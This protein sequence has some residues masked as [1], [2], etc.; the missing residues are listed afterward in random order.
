MCRR[1]RAASTRPVSEGWRG[2]VSSPEGRVDMPCVRMEKV[3]VKGATPARLACVQRVT[4]VRSS[5]APLTPR[6]KVRPTGK[7]FEPSGGG[8]S[9]S[10]SM[11]SWS[12]NGS[13]MAVAGQGR[14]GVS[15]GRHTAAPKQH[16]VRLS[17]SSTTSRAPQ[18]VVG[19][20]PG[21]G[22]G[23]A[24]RRQN[25]GRAWDIGIWRRG[26]VGVS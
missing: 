16:P 18:C 25:C 2:D 22:A 4:G 20:A 26:R 6:V 23:A 12:S 21:T 13:A 1:Q 14:G 9:C 24:T 5:T 17:N 7:S 11:A 15:R 8:V 19:G 10:R 3:E